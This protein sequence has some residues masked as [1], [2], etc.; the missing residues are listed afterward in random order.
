MSQL[1]IAVDFTTLSTRE[2]REAV[3][4][5]HALGTLGAI[6]DHDAI[7]QRG[8]TPTS[9]SWGMPWIPEYHR[10]CVAPE[11]DAASALGVWHARLCKKCFWQESTND[12]RLWYFCGAYEGKRRELLALPWPDPEWESHGR[13]LRSF[14]DDMVRRYGQGE[15]A[16][17]QL[18]AI[19]QRWFSVRI[20]QRFLQDGQYRA[21]IP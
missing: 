10:L 14:Y 9:T 12:P 6:D 13:L 21:L 17:A 1:L 2:L 8:E 3:P 20:L 5:A 18:Y 7:L 4:M 19:A 16:F 15:I 11:P